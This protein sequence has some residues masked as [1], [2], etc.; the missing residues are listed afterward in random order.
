MTVLMTT[1]YVEEADV[2]CH[3]VALMHL[4]VKRAEGPSSELKSALGTD[5]SLEDVFRHHTGRALDGDEAKG[6]A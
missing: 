1:H 3:R 5:A 2:L 6:H 4:G